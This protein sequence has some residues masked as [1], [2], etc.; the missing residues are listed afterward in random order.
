MNYDDRMRQIR[1]WVADMVARF[2]RPNHLTHDKAEQ[3]LRDMA[4]DLNYSLPSKITAD[5]LASTLDR[6][7]RA[8]RMKQRTRTWPT[9]QMV[10]SCARESLPKPDMLKPQAPQSMQA[11]MSD[12]INARRIK[13]G[14]AV[15]ESYIT[16]NGRDRLLDAKLIEAADLERYDQAIADR[17]TE[18]VKY[19]AQ[20]PSSIEDL[21]W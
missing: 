16:G 21:T 13:A 6:T 19:T 17:G 3:E 9:I 7:S 14:Q 12:R 18:A 2:D 10:I 1:P 11:N 5:S 8:I 4:E 20:D 15:A